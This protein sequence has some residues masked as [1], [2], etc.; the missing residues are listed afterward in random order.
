MFIRQVYSVMRQTS[1]SWAH[2]GQIE[3]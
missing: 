2:F 1:I 3:W